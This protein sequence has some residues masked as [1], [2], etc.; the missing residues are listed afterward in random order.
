LNIGDISSG[1]CQR[2][3]W[4]QHV[5]LWLLLF[6]CT[7]VQRPFCVGRRSV[8]NW[9]THTIADANWENFGDLWKSLRNLW[10][11]SDHSENHY[12]LSENDSEWHQSFS[13]KVTYFQAHSIDSQK[14][15][16]VSEDEWLFCATGQ[17]IALDVNPRN[18]H[19]FNSEAVSI[20]TLTPAISAV[21]KHMQTGSS[22][23]ALTT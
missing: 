8:K 6:F 3:L 5:A 12:V 18:Y 15:K 1:H 22:G 17:V 10:N 7:R 20:S 23:N 21:R 13:K 11:N 9:G 16:W 2:E 4:G 14:V 19:H